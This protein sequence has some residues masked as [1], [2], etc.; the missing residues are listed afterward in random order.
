ME[1]FPEFPNTKVIITAANVVEENYTAIANLREP[2]IVVVFDRVVGMQAIDVQEVDALI[3][4]L[5]GGFLKCG[6]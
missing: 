4:E 1:L 6:A 2:G 5:F 3:F